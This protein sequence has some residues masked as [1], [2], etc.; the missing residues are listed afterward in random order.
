MHKETQR[1]VDELLPWDEAVKMRWQCFHADRRDRWERI[2]KLRLS[3]VTMD[4]IA[5]RMGV[6]RETVRISIQT[7]LRSLR[8]LRALK[9]DASE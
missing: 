1:G 3:G 8:A 5:A 9:R 7:V 6:T 4:A 2:Y